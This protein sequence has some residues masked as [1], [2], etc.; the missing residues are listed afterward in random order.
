ME[1]AVRPRQRAGC[2]AGSG[3]V[4]K[5]QFVNGDGLGVTLAGGYRFGDPDRWHAGVG[6]ATER[7]PGAR[8]MAPHSI[9][10]ETGTPTDVRASRGPHRA[11][12]ALP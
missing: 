2:A 3:R 5:K 11:A 12:A 7:F 4:S 9:D 1:H 8:F 10:L 6:L